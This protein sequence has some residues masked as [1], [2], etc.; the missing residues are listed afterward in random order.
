M[1]T[2]CTSSKETKEKQEEIKVVY[3]SDCGDESNEV[4]KFCSGCGV[5]AKWISEKPEKI[6][7]ENSK[8]VEN[9][10]TISEELD[11]NNVKKEES[12]NK[13]TS[14]ELNKEDKELTYCSIC[15]VDTDIWSLNN[16]E[17]GLICNECK[18]ESSEFTG[19]EAISIAENYYNSKDDEDIFYEYDTEAKLDNKGVYYKVFVKSKDMQEQ[20]GNGTLFA[21]LVYEDGTVVEL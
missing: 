9:K 13:E 4:T 7:K 11:K 15:N 5:E 19:A 16:S 14:E 18:I 12:K 8:E 17:Y 21:I 1:V 10:E 3:C 2:G 20:G 6:D